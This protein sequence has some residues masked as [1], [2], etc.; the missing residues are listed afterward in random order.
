MK[1]AVLPNKK[2]K[3][4]IVM[5]FCTTRKRHQF[6]TIEEVQEAHRLLRAAV[7]VAS[8]CDGFYKVELYQ[9]PRFYLEVYRHAHFNVI[10]RIS[11][12]KDTAYL[13]PYLQQVSLDGLLSSL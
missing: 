11:R 5:H 4:F 13:E 7:P 3:L 1:T 12:F 2:A 8:R 6:T 10:I 9:A